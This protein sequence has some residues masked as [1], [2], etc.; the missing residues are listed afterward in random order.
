MG[1]VIGVVNIKGG[2]GKSTISAHLAAWLYDRGETVAFI[3]T[4]GQGSSSVWLSNAEPKIRTE[5]I[6]DYK[7][8]TQYAKAAANAHN[9]VI[10]DGPATLG[11]T[12]RGILLVSDIA[13]L[14]CV[15]SSLDWGSLGQTISE[16]DNCRM[17]REGEKPH[18]LI[19]CNKMDERANLSRE[20]LEFAQA[21]FRVPLARG[22]IHLWQIYAEAA[23]RLTFVGRMGREGE[24]AAKEMESLF[25]EVCYGQEATA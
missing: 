10:C 20:F 24:R 11:E 9:F 12:T 6:H 13:L 14:P 2:V 21:N 15:P 19:V 25:M 8:L 22:L 23:R 17:L 16:L 3:D 1:T 4:D 5:R 7:E 18:A